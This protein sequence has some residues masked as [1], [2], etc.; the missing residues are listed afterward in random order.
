MIETTVNILANASAKVGMNI[1]NFKGDE[2]INSDIKKILDLLA[3][4]AKT[5]ILDTEKVNEVLGKI[6][7]PKKEKPI[8]KK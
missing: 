1:R 6:K 3:N 4:Y 2:V 8:E 5:G 7:K